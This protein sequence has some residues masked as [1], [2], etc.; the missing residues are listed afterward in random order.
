MSQDVSVTSVN[1]AAEAVKW[2]FTVKHPNEHNATLKQIWE[3][4]PPRIF[5]GTA[6]LFYR[7]MLHGYPDIFCLVPAY[8]NLGQSAI[9]RSALDMAPN[10]DGL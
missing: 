9:L 10:T 4:V 3:I 6:M 1:Q 7:S 5:T 2:F 8:D